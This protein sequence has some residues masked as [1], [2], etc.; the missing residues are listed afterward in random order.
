MARVHRLLMSAECRARREG[1]A[2]HTHLHCVERL[3]IR[4]RAVLRGMFPAFDLQ[5]DV[6]C[7]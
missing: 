4:A 2:I 5:L 1:S 7:Q 3:A 6:G